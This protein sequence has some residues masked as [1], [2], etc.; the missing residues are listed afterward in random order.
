MAPVRWWFF[1]RWWLRKM[2]KAHFNGKTKSTHP[3]T[4]EMLKGFRMDPT[5]AQISLKGWFL[6]LLEGQ[7]ETLLLKVNYGGLNKEDT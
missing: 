4:W 5:L 3:D 2:V 6:E 7:S 1:C